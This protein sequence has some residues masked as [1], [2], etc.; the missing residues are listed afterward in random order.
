MWDFFETV[1]HRHSIRSYRSEIPVEQSHLHAVLET[2]CAAPSAGDAQSYKIIVVSEQDTRTAL[3]K[4]SE[5]Q[6]FVTQAPMCLIFCAD[7]ER[8]QEHFGERGATL[9]ALQDATIAATYSQLAIVAAGMASTWV[10]KFD[11]DEV[12]GI[13]NL[14]DHLRPVA[15]LCLGYPAELPEPSPRRP[16][17]EVVDWGIS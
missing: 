17:A 1:R 2:A 13:L 11:E 6:S 9:Y 16:L 10:G 3:A 4:A 14:P 5:E 7:M 8:A 12:G 15:L